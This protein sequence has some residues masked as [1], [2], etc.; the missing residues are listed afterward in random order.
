MLPGYLCVI[1]YEIVSE[2]VV[3]M[4]IILH[5]TDYIIVIQCRTTFDKVLNT[6][7]HSGI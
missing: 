6:I 4:F 1:V 5:T 2:Q 7:Y 3:L